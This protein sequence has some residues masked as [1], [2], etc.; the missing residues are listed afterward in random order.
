M[1]RTTTL[2]LIVN[3]LSNVLYWRDKA[4]ERARGGD[5]ME[6]GKFGSAAHAEYRPVSASDR[7]F[8]QNVTTSEML[9][10]TWKGLVCGI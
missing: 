2:D 9:I 8:F 4:T 5:S 10:I 7:V 1:T 6:F 3:R